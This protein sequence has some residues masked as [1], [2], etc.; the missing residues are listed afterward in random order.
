MS[1]LWPRTRRIVLRER[2]SQGDVG[3]FAA[4]LGWPRREEYQADPEEGLLYQVVWGA[5]PKLSL[6]YFE[7]DISRL[8]YVVVVGE[9]AV[10]VRGAEKLIETALD[11]YLLDD[12]ISEVDSAIDPIP[13]A[14]AIVRA[15]AGSP[16]EFDERF[17]GRISEALSNPDERVREAALWATTYVPYK[18]YMPQLKRLRDDDP[19]QDLR[20]TAESVIEGFEEA[21]VED[22]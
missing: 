20:D 15:G 21:G 12:L 17:F 10:A 2:Y 7:D 16:E 22:T 6:C 8:S 5:G 13:L 3:R 11:V 1:E 4:K 18:E 14:R 9:D 19:V